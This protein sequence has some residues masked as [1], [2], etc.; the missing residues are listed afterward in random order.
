MVQRELMDLIK[1]RDA[2]AASAT[3]K[4]S[5]LQ[6]ARRRL[7]ELEIESLRVG[8]QNIHL[9]SEVL[10]LSG[11]T[12]KQSPKALGGG[13]LANEM[14]VLEGQVKAARHKW[15]VMKGT[16]SAIVAGSGVEWA[17]DERLR[18]MVLDPSN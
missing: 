2:V 11:R 10:Q 12:Q 4:C 17:R 7:A 8:Q 1:Q 5:D 9:A 3:N 15:K 18:A 16:A 13:K 14:A 6:A